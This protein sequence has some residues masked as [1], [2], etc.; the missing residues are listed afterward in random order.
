MQAMGGVTPNIIADF[1]TNIGDGTDSTIVY[2]NGGLAVTWIF[3]LQY[4]TIPST[5]F[6]AR[7]GTALRWKGNT[8]GNY[9]IGGKIYRPTDPKPSGVA[10]LTPNN[11]SAFTTT[12][13]EY[14]SVNW[15]LSDAGGLLYMWQDGRANAAWP[16]TDT[17][18]VWGTIYTLAKATATPGNKTESS[19]VY[20]TIPVTVATTIDWEASTYDWQNLRKVT[21]EVRIEQGGTGVGTGTLLS[22][23]SQSQQVVATGSESWNI[24]MPDSLPNGTY[25]VYTRALR[26]REDGL[27]YSDAYS[28]WSTAATLTMSAPLPVTPTMTVTGDDSSDS[29]RISVTPTSS[30]GYLGPYIYVQRSDDAGATWSDVRNASGVAGAFGTASTFIDYEAPRNQAALYR[31]KVEAT[32][33]SAYINASAW[34]APATVNLSSNTWNLKVPSNSDLNAIG[35][36]VVGHPTENVQENL[37]VF[38]PLGR[39]YPVVVAGTLSGWDGE[40]SIICATNAEWLQLKALVEAQTIILLQSTFGWSKYVRI[41][42]GVKGELYGTTTAPKRTISLSYVEVDKPAIVT[43]QTIPTVVIPSS[44]D[45]GTASVT[46]ADFFDGGTA[47]STYIATID[48]GAAS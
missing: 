7:V 47:T 30:T 5:E 11:S 35:V 15:P 19:S 2:N 32:Y 26:Y 41:M 44:L 43:G 20:P 29:V 22:Q 24:T 21:V 6:M 45:G 33:S 39:K 40:L 38:R 8:N 17:A 14:Q 18:D 36:T 23:S 48:G 25:K 9:S 10:T 16:R 12:Q 27:V 34:A 42:S 1:M 37:G 13:V 31:A 3:R 4:P 46:F 28:S